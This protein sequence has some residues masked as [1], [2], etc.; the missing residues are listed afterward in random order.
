MTAASRLLIALVRMYQVT[1]SPFLGGACR[2]APSCSHYAVGAIREHGAGRGTWLAFRR[3]ARC[4]PFHP[5][6]L[7]PVPSGDRRGP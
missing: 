4:H 1:L 6:G 3:L 7:D 5:G 2:F